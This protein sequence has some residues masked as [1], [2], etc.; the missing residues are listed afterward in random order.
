[1]YPLVLSIAENI[2]HTVR[3]G[4]L[5]VQILKRFCKSGEI[6]GFWQDQVIA[7]VCHLARDGYN[8]QYKRNIIFI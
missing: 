1:M 8:L 2:H 3:K 5:R 4:H 7:R 6:F